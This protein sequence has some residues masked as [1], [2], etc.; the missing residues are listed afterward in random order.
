MVSDSSIK[1]SQAEELNSIS[2]KDWDEDDENDK[3]K[4]IRV[5]KRQSR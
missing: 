4:T 1:D 3:H 2:E 5:I